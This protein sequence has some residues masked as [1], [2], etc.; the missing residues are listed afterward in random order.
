MLTFWNS[1]EV[2]FDGDQFFERM[3]SDIDSAQNYITV[4]VYIFNNDSLGRRV[5]D[6]LIE[7]HKRGVRVQVIVD[8]VGSHLFAETLQHVFK[9]HGINVKMYNP[10][11]FI[12][13]FYG[14]ISIVR[15]FQIFSTRILRLNK[16]DH[17]KIITIDSQIMY[18]GSFNITAEHTRLHSEIPWKDMGVRVTG[19]QVKFAVLNFKK[20]WKLRDYYRYKKQIRNL[21]HPNWRHSPLKLNHTVFMRR[22][23]YKNF[24]N[25]IKNAQ[26]RIWLTTPYFIP[27]R[28]LIRT[29]GKAAQRGVDVRILISHRS[30][31][32]LFRTLQYFYYGYLLKKGIKVYH[33][34]ESVLH[35]KNYIIDDWITIGTTNL[36]H[37]SFMHD[38][39]V[40]LI[41][42][43]EKNKTLIEQNFI[44]STSED[45]SITM[46]S[47]NRRPLF[48][49]F[50]SRLFF[51]F[52]YWF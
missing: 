27:K 41:I 3:I 7:A 28:R 13:P 45:N 51:I 36:N 19:E 32:K 15:K 37:R 20:V 42:Q 49:R 10:L 12:H 6:R 2:F 24:L 50:L 40:D 17:R 1:E 33:Y 22:Y 23:F 16:R 4:E 9:K 48:D 14:N 5:A 34:T 18:T 43:D 29:L 8:G 30:D 31:V 11:P 21:N 44:E 46:E 39:E 25:R 35:A 47:L 26:S 52:K 38:L